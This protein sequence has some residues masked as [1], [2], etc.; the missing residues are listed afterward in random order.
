MKIGTNLYNIAAS[1]EQPMRQDNSTPHYDLFTQYNPFPMLDQSYIHNNGQTSPAMFQLFSSKINE[2]TYS[3]GMPDN[4]SASSQNTYGAALNHS[5]FSGQN[6]QRTPMEGLFNGEIFI[7]IFFKMYS[8]RSIINVSTLYFLLEK[9]TKTSNREG[10]VE[11]G[12]GLNDT[13]FPTLPIINHPIN[14]DGRSSLSPIGTKP[15][16]YASSA[17][18]TE[19][20]YHRLEGMTLLDKALNEKPS[21]EEVQKAMRSLLF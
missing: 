15:Q 9:L 19:P 2:Q 11:H 16:T 18:S 17:E 4:N 13:D 8:T 5:F 20:G 12:Y 10:Q 21:D 7:F 1:P 3:N 6:V 14:T